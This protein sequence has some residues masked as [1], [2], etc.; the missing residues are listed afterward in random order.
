VIYESYS[1]G[2]ECWIRSNSGP[3]LA[4]ISAAAASGLGDGMAGDQCANEGVEVADIGVSE[5][6]LQRQCVRVGAAY[7]VAERRSVARSGVDSVL[8]ILAV[9]KQCFGMWL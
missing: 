3:R 8:S 2:F 5:T 9:V 6:M 4:H 7:V 1:S